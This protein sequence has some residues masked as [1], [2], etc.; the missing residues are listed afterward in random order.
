MLAKRAVV[1]DQNVINGEE[2]ENPLRK[3]NIWGWGTIAWKQ[4]RMLKK[5]RVQ[6][7]D[8][9]IGFAYPP[10]LSGCEPCRILEQ[11]FT[12]FRKVG[13]ESTIV[14]NSLT[15]KRNR[16]EYPQH[17]WAD[18]TYI[19]LWTHFLSCVS[20]VEPLCYSAHHPSARFTKFWKLPFVCQSCLVYTVYIYID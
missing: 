1:Q 5:H 4:F 2:A 6:D 11:L 20:N 9:D 7:A 3:Y 17:I 12:A 10:P 15:K 8:K 19:F 16:W 18:I 14:S 13:T